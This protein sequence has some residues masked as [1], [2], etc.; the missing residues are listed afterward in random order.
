[1]V[2]GGTQF[3]ILSAAFDKF[4][5]EKQLKSNA[6]QHL[7][8]IYV[9]GNQEAEVNENFLNECKRRFA[10]LESDENAES[11]EQIKN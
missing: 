7:V 5:D 6:I 3:G 2:I 8:D 4:G 10:L 11:E 1:M 9:K